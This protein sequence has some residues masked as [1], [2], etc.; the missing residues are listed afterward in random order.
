MLKQPRPVAHAVGYALEGLGFYHIPHPLLLKGKKESKMALVACTG[1]QLTKEQMAAQ[2]CKLFPAKWKWELVEHDG[3]SYLVPFPSRADLK[4]AIAFGGA[5]VKE[6][7]ISNGIRLL[8]EEWSEKEEGFLLPKVWV[9]VFGYE[10][11]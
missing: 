11:R 4:R 3:S 9:R 2:L 6:S 1:G 8:F 10:R 5:D 7:G